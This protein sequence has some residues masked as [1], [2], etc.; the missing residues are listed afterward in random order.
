MSE[1]GK[2]YLSKEIAL[3]LATGSWQ[4][5]TGSIHNFDCGY[6]YSLICGFRKR[7]RK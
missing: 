4:L 5:A 3:L 1:S 2:F 7:F 6:K